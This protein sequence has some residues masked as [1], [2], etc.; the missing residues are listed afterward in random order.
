MK[1]HSPL[2]YPIFDRPLIIPKLNVCY[3]DSPTCGGPTGFWNC[4]RRPPVF[5]NCCPK[6]FAPICC[7][8]I[9]PSPWEWRIR[10]LCYDVSFFILREFGKIVHSLLIKDETIDVLGR[11]QAR[12]FWLTNMFDT[13]KKWTM[14]LSKL[15]GRFNRNKKSQTRHIL[16]RAGRKLRPI[17]KFWPYLE[18]QSIIIW[19]PIRNAN[20]DQVERRKVRDCGKRKLTN[21]CFKNSFIYITLC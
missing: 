6:P 21:L 8:C 17:V 19:W 14:S 4:S 11:N 9:I 15:R 20:F 2:P 5:W 7:C 10:M 1:I 16:K 13:F 3:K 18:A 12:F